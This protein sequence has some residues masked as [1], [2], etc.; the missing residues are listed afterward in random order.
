M[1]KRS[2]G[3]Q[4]VVVQSTMLFTALMTIDC[5]TRAQAPNP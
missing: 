1:E 5:H 2:M 4:R 3:R